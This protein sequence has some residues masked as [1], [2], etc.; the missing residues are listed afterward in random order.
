MSFTSE[1]TT[2]PNAAPITTPTARST[3]LPFIANSRNSFSMVPSLVVVASRGSSSEKRFD[4]LQRVDVLLK[5]V[6]VRLD[7]ADRRA[8]LRRRAER[9]TLAAGLIH[10]CFAEVIEL[11]VGGPLARGARDPSCGEDRQHAADARSTSHRPLAH[12]SPP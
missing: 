3:T 12:R 4:R 1:S 9:T 7:V 6:E 10:R 8:E 11:R 2:L 5:R